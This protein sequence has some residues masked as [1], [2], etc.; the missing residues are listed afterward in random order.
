MNKQ[1][2]RA[3]ETKGR[4]RFAGAPL[5]GQLLVN[6]GMADLRLCLPPRRGK[7][8][9]A[10]GKG[11]QRLPPWVTEP[12][13]SCPLFMVCRA[14]RWVGTADHEEWGLFIMTPFP[15]AAPR[16][17]WAIIFRPSGASRLAHGARK[18]PNDQLTDGGP[19]LTPELGMRRRRAAIRRSTWFGILLN[20]A[21]WVEMPEPSKN[22]APHTSPPNPNPRGSRRPLSQTTHTR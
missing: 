22:R 4:C 16:L 8:K 10:Q 18:W 6:F 21:M 20:Q 2:R 5:F 14:P 11:A 15:R 12:I 1:S 3:A 9:I 13:S 7:E 19:P 17:P